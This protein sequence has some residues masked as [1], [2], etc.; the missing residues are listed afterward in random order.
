MICFLI[1]GEKQVKMDD[2]PDRGISAFWHFGLFVLCA[3]NDSANTVPLIGH[4]IF[5]SLLPD[6]TRCMYFTACTS[7]IRETTWIGTPGPAYVLEQSIKCQRST[8]FSTERPCESLPVVAQLRS[9]LP[10]SQL[11]MQVQVIV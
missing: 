5:Y 3:E 1:R 10:T 7:H 6:T 4:Y 8:T 9:N 11:D 2:R